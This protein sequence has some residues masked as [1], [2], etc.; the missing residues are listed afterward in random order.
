LNF[1]LGGALFVSV[2]QNVFTNKLVSGLASQVPGVD[3][4]I[5]LSVGATSLRNSVD[6]QYLPAVLSVYNQA[7]ISAYY[8]SVAMACFSLIGALAI[9]WRSVKGKNIEMAMG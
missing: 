5:V 3:P 2:G 4:T 1:I 7:L 9:E 6:A 8:V